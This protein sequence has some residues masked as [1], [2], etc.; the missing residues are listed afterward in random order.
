M[1]KITSIEGERLQKS[2]MKKKYLLQYWSF[3]LI[4]Q[5]KPHIIQLQNLIIGNMYTGIKVHCKFF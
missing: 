3:P 2:Q 1:F 5:V 4:I